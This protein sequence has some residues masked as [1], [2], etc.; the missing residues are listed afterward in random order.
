[1][2]KRR[3]WFAYLL[4]F[5]I[6]LAV[7]GWLGFRIGEIGETPSATPISPFPEVTRPDQ[8]SLL[9][10]GVDRVDSTE[11][12][13]QG[14][15]YVVY[16]QNHPRI[17]LI[18]LYPAPPGSDSSR[19]A[20]LEEKFRLHSDGAVDPAFFRATQDRFEMS[21]DGYILLDDIA[22]IE[23]VDFFGGV[24]VNGELISGPRAVGSIPRPWDNSPD[25]VLQ[26]AFLVETICENITLETT[27][28][29]YDK[30]L[31]L[32]PEHLQTELTTDEA[33]SDWLGLLSSGDPLIC[34]FPSLRPE[35]PS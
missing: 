11:A 31:S 15:W 32:I 13:L 18:P 34:D 23:I 1:M 22:M 35:T 28:K 14:A 21:W 24:T 12:R 10:L 7:G 17:T 19:Q 25:A 4:L 27:P 6:S 20:V 8:R 29:T 26:Q 3:R 2:K 9:I 33:F 16:R 30:I 5:G